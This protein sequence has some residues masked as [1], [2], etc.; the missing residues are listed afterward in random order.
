MLNV[1]A[2]A[3]HTT[4]FCPKRHI[5]KDDK[6]ISFSGQ[7]QFSIVLVGYGGAS[8]KLCLKAPLHYKW[9]HD[10]KLSMMPPDKPIAGYPCCLSLLVDEHFVFLLIFTMNT[11]RWSGT[12]EDSQCL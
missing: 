4:R 8:V 3:A 7:K 12:Y 5:D 9:Y 6:L 10:P 1:A 11:L 2:V